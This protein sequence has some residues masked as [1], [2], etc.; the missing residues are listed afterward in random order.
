MLGCRFAE[1]LNNPADPISIAKHAI[2]GPEDQKHFGGSYVLAQR[3][4]IDWDRVNN[5]TETQIEDLVGRNLDQEI[6]PDRHLFSHIKSG[7]LQNEHGDTQS[8]LRLGLPFGSARKDDKSALQ[9]TSALQKVNDEE[10]IFF[11][12]YCNSAV[13]LE[14]IMLNQIGAA[15]RMLSMMNSTDGGFFYIPS[16]HDLGVHD[17]DHANRLFGVSYFKQLVEDREVCDWKKFP[18]VDWERLNRH[19]KTASANGLMYY[20]HQ[21]YL[22]Q[23]ATNIGRPDAVTTKLP[24][25]VFCLF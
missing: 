22:F 24:L 19:Y 21:N 14:N 20:N 18:G 4:L 12:G 25:I 9:L 15:D 2:I 16:L 10:G 5:L 8:I 11:A 13:T 3:F 7:R 17:L 1:N 23:M 6:I